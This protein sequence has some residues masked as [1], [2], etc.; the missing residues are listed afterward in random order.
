[1]FNPRL[2]KRFH[3]SAILRLHMVL[4]SLILFGTAVTFADPPQ[5]T[6][7][8]IVSD[9]FTK[10]RQETASATPSKG[11]QG[12]AS[13]SIPPKPRQPRRTYR[14]ASAPI[15]G[16]RPT[17]N[18]SVVAQLGITIWRLRPVDANDAGGRALIREK[19]KSSG[20][21][22]ER[23]EGET[24]FREG[25]HVRISVE[26]PRAGYL[27]VVDRDLFSDGTTGGAML[28]YPWSATDNQ[29]RPG[30]LVDIPAQEDDP[31]YFTARLTGA[32]QVGELLT[33]IVTSSPLDL[34]ISD[35]PF[36]IATGQMRNWEKVWG[37]ESERFEM[38]GGAGEAWTQQEQQAAA[39]KGTRQLTR[40]DPAP[41]TIY[42]V[43][44][45][46]QKAILV[47]VRLRYRK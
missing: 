20:L 4:L 41:Q 37:G 9:D 14:L 43:S 23:V 30:R 26:S 46:D 24:M 8:K 44:T 39:K 3:G 34:P 17:T 47:N 32:N 11:S 22:P 16:P 5:G 12:E 35:K 19:G 40:D 25:D 45:T 28:I 18:L 2:R 31:S 27:Y 15:K 38:E 42:R 1:M 10:N 29:M 7:R 13:K 33:F 6:P 36:Q 21:V